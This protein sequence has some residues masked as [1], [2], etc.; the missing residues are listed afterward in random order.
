MKELDVDLLFLNLLFLHYLYCKFL[1]RSEVSAHSDVA[2]CSLADNFSKQV[3]LLHI[4]HEFELLVIVN[5]ES[6]IGW[7][8]CMLPKI[9][10]GVTVVVFILQIFFDIEHW[11]R[12]ISLMFTVV[13]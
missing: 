12:V 6:S 10:P 8:P 4:G 5:V 13:S 9:G 3:G 1:T 2:E 7:F 11:H